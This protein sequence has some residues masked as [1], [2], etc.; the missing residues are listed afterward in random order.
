MPTEILPVATTAAISTPVTTPADERVTLFLL[1]AD[2]QVSPYVRV[3]MQFQGTAGWSTVHDLRTLAPTATFV[4]PVTW[5][6]VRD[7]EYAGTGVGVQR[8]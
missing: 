8:A 7:A 6:V 2:P 5:R 3:R 1:G 4:G